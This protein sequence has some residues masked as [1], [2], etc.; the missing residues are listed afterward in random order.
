MFG[1]ALFKEGPGMRAL[2]TELALE[3]SIPGRCTYQ[4]K[5]PLRLGPQQIQVRKWAVGHICP[6]SEWLLGP[7]AVAST[8]AC[9]TA[10]MAT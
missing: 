5:E 8:L 10:R 4:T 2:A 1:A 3:I 9:E 6:G 7:L